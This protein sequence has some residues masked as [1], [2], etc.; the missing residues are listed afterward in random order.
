[1]K[2]LNAIG[3]VLLNL[4]FLSASALKAQAPLV[5]WENTLGTTGL[6]FMTDVIQTNDG[7]YLAAGFSYGG[8]SGDKTDPLNGFVDY[9]IVK[10][11][12]DGLIKWDLWRQRIRGGGS[13]DRNLLRTFLAYRVVQ[14]TGK[15]GE[16]GRLEWLP[17][18][19]DGDD[20]F[21]RQRNLG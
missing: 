18:F 19:L 9:W 6:D 13:Y 4:S 1:M 2:P 14:F 10:L 12:A 21:G 17:G 20:R 15:R 3:L 8:V 5:E 7:G 11:D 16:D